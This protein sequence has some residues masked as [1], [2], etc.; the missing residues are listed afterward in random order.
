MS[1][2]AVKEWD[3]Q[4]MI[5]TFKTQG[6][7]TLEQLR[8][9]LAGTGPVDFQVATHQ[10]AYELIRETLI[11]FRYERLGKADRGLIRAYLGKVSGLSRAQIS[12]LIKQ[13]RET[14]T[15]RDRRGRPV[16][17]FQRIYTAQDIALLAEVDRLHSQLSGPATRK[18]CERAY[19]VFG[20]RRFERLAHLSNGHLY[21]LRRS[22]T[23]QRQR[24]VVE[25]TRPTQ[26]P[27]G[28]RRKPRPEGRPGYLRVDS[29][30]QGDQDGIKGLYLINLIDE[31][32]PIPVRRRRRAHQ[33]TLPGPRSV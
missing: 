13:F 30:H 18:L 8:A 16:R 31:I 7:Q 9:F 25:R 12:R 2:K 21:N 27:I 10:E 4:E 11:R 17:P 26:V 23:Y 15:V 14:H 33:R 22:K 29:V 20:D 3:H 32:H 1:L 28:E 6:L 24:I 5:V 19:Q